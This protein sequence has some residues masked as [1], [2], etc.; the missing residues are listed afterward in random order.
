VLKIFRDHFK[1]FVFLQVGVLDAGRF[2]GA[3]E[4]E[5][6]KSSVEGEL[7]KYV[8]YMKRHNFQS[9]G[10]YSIGTDVVTEI[11]NLALTIT[12]RY[13]GCVLFAGQ[14]VF[15]DESVITRL[16]HNYTAFAVQRRLYHHGIPVFIVP[17]AAR[18]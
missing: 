4:V 3:E 15:D 16:L 1:K 18:G 12:E 9:E 17:I 2:K 10:T 13:P 11:E 14:I 7:Q 8:D 6:L 5:N